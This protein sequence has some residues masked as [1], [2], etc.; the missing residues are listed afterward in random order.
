MH[1]TTRDPF[2]DDVEYAAELA[3]INAPEFWA[4]ADDDD[5]IVD[6]DV[7][8]LET[9]LALASL[10]AQYSRLAS[11]D[12]QINRTSTRGR[13]SPWHGVRVSQRNEL[14]RRIRDAQERLEAL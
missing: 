6:D 11:L 8:K 12:A 2:A 4:P 10:A 13:K 5:T 7:S 3:S 9:C 1:A 14:A